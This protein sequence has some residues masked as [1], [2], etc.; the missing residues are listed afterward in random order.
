MGDELAA[1]MA[2][3]V[4]VVKAKAPSV[5]RK[6]V[7][8]AGVAKWE[9]GHTQFVTSQLLHVRF[10]PKKVR[11]VGLG[12]NKISPFVL[13]ITQS[14]CRVM[15][16]IHHFSILTHLNPWSHPMKTPT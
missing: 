2:L 15:K 16:E 12:F 7:R 6:G 9:V 11:L 5:R 4:A 13:C 1:A 14:G 10:Q 3:V 8:G